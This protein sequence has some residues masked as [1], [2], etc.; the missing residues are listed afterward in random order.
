M[1]NKNIEFW[2]SVSKT[3][4]K[5]TKEIRN[6]GRKMTAI[7]AQYQLMNATKKWGKYGDKWGLRDIKL[8][9]IDNL[10]K[11]QILCVSNAV[12]EYPGGKFE[13]GSSIFVQQFVK[14]SYLSIDSDFLKK[15]E[16]DMLTKSL[17]KLGFN[18]D[19]FLGKYDDNKY[20]RQI[21][22]EF[23]EQKQKPKLT[24]SPTELLDELNNYKDI[25]KLREFVKKFDI[26]ESKMEIIKKH[27]EI[28]KNK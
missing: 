6:G 13:I 10:D 16:T 11:G 23:S 7:N 21:E 17:S 26:D 24:L 22:L 12:F 18:A 14:Q 20:V 8:N 15:L 1:E 28:I 25:D 4:P 27:A 9:Y 3:D 5:F 2:E 19:V